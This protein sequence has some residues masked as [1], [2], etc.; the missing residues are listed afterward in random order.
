MIG[1]A[2]SGKFIT[3]VGFHYYASISDDN[4]FTCWL[5]DCLYQ[6]EGRLKVAGVYEAIWTSRYKQQRGE[7]MMKAL[8]ARW[9]PVTNTIF[10]CYG[11]LGISLWDV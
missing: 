10:T 11:E 7:G 2:P 6:F 4:R 1:E 8:V 3:Q 9:S 5:C